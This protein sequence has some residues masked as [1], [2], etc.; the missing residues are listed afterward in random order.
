[1]LTRECRFCGQ[2]VGQYVVSTREMSPSAKAVT[3]IAAH[4]V[5]REPG[6]KPPDVPQR[7]MTD[8][9]ETTPVGDLPCPRSPD[10]KHQVKGT[11]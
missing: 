2:V 1:M 10:G 4:L 8:G 9:W 3:L 5:P 11:T 6:T 7:W